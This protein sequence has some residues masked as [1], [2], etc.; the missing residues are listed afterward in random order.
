M[1]PSQQ[2]ALVGANAPSAARGPEG[3]MA[4][5]RRLH[6]ALA[7]SAVAY[8]D[9]SLCNEAPELS[10]ERVASLESDAGSDE[11][12]EVIDGRLTSSRARARHEAAEMM[13]RRRA[14]EDRAERCL[15]D[16]VAARSMLRD[17]EALLRDAPSYAEEGEDEREGT[18]GDDSGRAA[19][20]P[21]TSR[22][23]SATAPTAGRTGPARH[24]APPLRPTLS[25]RPLASPRAA[26]PACAAAVGAAGA[27]ARAQSDALR[28]MRLQRCDELNTSLAPLRAGVDEHDRRLE[29][30]AAVSSR[31]QSALHS[32]LSISE[33]ELAAEMAL[34][35]KEGAGAG[36]V[37]VDAVSDAGYRRARDKL[38][39]FYA[40]SGTRPA[41]RATRGERPPGR[42]AG[43][44]VAG[45][46]TGAGAS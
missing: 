29:E 17:I 22:P 7:A 10:K 8:T 28:S 33:D 19:G 20:S 15:M 9:A 38:V 45:G 4:S 5:G 37:D 46:K 11:E 6:D 23:A 40:R 43:A 27:D 12:A 21:S 16:N 1:S 32:A 42:P 14:L 2:E 3:S 24:S 41:R 26:A 44:G 18:S 13:S 34:Q 25:G 31:L 35:A 36:Q 39:S 30:A